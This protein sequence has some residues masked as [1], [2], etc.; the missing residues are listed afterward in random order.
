MIL[1]DSLNSLP[2]HKSLDVSADNITDLPSHSNG[3][4]ARSDFN[5]ELAKIMIHENVS[6]WNVDP[7]SDLK[8]DHKTLIAFRYLF[9]A[10]NRGYTFIV[11]HLIH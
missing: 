2:N 11:N 8:S 1:E 6:L 4:A 5:V 10:C 3:S 9:W 7:K